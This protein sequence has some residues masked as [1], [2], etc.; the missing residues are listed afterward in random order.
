VADSGGGGGG[1]FNLSQNIYDYLKDKGVPGDVAKGAII[2]MMG[3]SGRSLDP[4]SYNDKDPGGSVGFAQWN[5][6]R[7]AALET[8][9]KGQGLDPHSAEAQFNYWKAELEGAPGAINQPDVLDALKAGKSVYDGTSIWTRKFERP[10]V[11]NSAQRFIGN[12]KAVN[13]DDSGKLMIAAGAPSGAT[14]ESTAAPAPTFGQALQKGDVGGALAALTA[15]T[16][17]E[18]D[19]PSALENIA[20]TFGGDQQQQQSGMRESAPMLPQAQDTSAAL[21]GPA[22]QLWQQTVASMARP[23]TWSSAPPGAGAGQQY[24]VPGMTLNS[25]GPGYG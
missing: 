2:S 3:E 16:G 7:R 17:K 21:Y 4:T 5:G 24:Q 25:V 8:M 18:G 10:T 9:A 6:P 23:L 20:K 13:V 1:G 15:K 12:Y 22:S 11:D 14:S 19:Q